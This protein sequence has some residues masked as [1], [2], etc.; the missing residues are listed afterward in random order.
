MEV[1]GN[2]TVVCWLALAFANAV[3][4]SSVPLATTELRMAW[5]WICTVTVMVVDAP[6]TKD[7]WLQVTV[8]TPEPPAVHVP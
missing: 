4:A 1:A 3:P 7:P 2:G 5:L 8:I 6:A